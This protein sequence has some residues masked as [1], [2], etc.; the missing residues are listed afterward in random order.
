MMWTPLPQS[1]SSPVSKG[2]APGQVSVSMSR[3]VLL[4][5]T[6]GNP[7]DCGIT[8]ASHAPFGK[9][10][11]A[12]HSGIVNNT[13]INNQSIHNGYL[14]P[15]AGAGVGIFSDGSG[16]GL[17]H[18]NQVLN[19]KLLNN[20]IPGVAFHSHV[21]PNFFLPPDD[22]NDNVIVGNYISGNGA[23]VGDTPTP[24]LTGINVNSGMGG[25][26]IT[27]TVIWGNTITNEADDVV[28]N[29]PAEVDLHFNNLLGG[30]TGVDNLGP[31]T[32]DART[33]Y[34]GC[35]GGPGAKGCSTISGPD[36]TFVPFLFIPVP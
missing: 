31:G 29:T 36:V 12:P 15:G 21:G 10:P 16:I 7:Y 8:L 19:N 4:P 28:T 14:I 30:A 25:T 2:G 24:G 1:K 18:G 26:P 3:T 32:V 27:G 23:D 5:V 17:V 6:K 33:N 35:F 22:L 34:W 9:D 11:T 13:V 20:G